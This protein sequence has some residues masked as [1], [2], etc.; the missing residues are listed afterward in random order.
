MPAPT[1]R[2]GKLSIGDDMP[3]TRSEAQR[4]ASGPPAEP[5]RGSS[6]GEESSSEEEESPP[7][8]VLEGPFS[9]PYDVGALSAVS[10][11]RASAGLKGDFNVEQCRRTSNNDYEFQIRDRGRVLVNDSGSFCSCSEFSDGNACKHIYVCYMHLMCE[12]LANSYQWLL[13]RILPSVWPTREQVGV[14][15]LDEDLSSAFKQIHRRLN[16]EKTAHDQNWIIVP[17]RGTVSETI[18]ESGSGTSRKLEVQD[19]LS[20]FEENLLPADYRQDIFDKISNTREDPQNCVEQ[21]DLQG[22]IFRLAVS[23]DAVYESLRK[24]MP[25]GLRANIFFEKLRK[26]MNDVLRVLDEYA[27]FGTRR[28]DDLQV[29]PVEI[30]VIAEELRDCVRKVHANVQIRSPYGQRYAARPVIALLEDICVKRNCDVF[31][32]S[33]WGREE[34]PGEGHDDRN[35]FHHLMVRTPEFGSLI[36]DILEDLDNDT[37]STFKEH[38]DTIRDHLKFTR[39]PLPFV[40][41]L[42]DVLRRLDTE[43]YQA[44]EQSSASAQQPTQPRRTSHGLEAGEQPLDETRPGHAPARGRGRPTPSSSGPAGQKRPAADPSRGKKKRPR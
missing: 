5:G 38:L 9:I 26:G 24:A 3:T 20:A 34:P 42:G 11:S 28:P 19:I 23:D 1:E 39:E 8:E 12:P 14:F 32:R 33:D 27:R 29:Q 15:R 7:K 31:E 44:P 4:R 37:L 25:A 10:R 13:G 2:L 30:S 21:M 22:T 41:R 16:L 43:A 17:N 40:K 18:S 36:L 6:S 35:L